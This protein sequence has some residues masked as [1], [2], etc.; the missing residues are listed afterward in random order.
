MELNL[1]ENLKKYRQEKGNTQD[2]L[3]EFLNMSKQSVSKWERDEGFP[4]I[5][6]LP[7][8][9]AYYDVTVDDLLGCGEIE[10]QRRLTEFEEQ[11]QQLVNQNRMTD[12]LILCRT[13]QKEYPNEKRVLDYLMSALG[14]EDRG[15]NATEIIE[16]AERLLASGDPEYRY[17]ALQNLTMTYWWQ[18]DYEQAKKYAAMAESPGDLML[19]ALRG[20]ERL[21]HCRRYFWHLCDR[22]TG[23]MGYLFDDDPALTAAEKYDC[24]RLN[25]DLYHRIFRDG[26][27]GFFE[28]RLAY[29]C[30]DLAKYSMM[31]GETSRALGEL[32]DGLE[33]C[34]KYDEFVSI[35]HSSP[36]VR[37]Q[38]YED[39][40]AGR[41]GCG[42]TSVLMLETMSEPCFDPIREDERFKAV[43]NRL[44]NMKK[45]YPEQEFYE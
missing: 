12:Y 19:F 30:C 7:K 8:I 43:V 15:K 16:I 29:L 6:L 41:A 24:V 20:E 36:L 34:R 40:M 5:T 3:A 11:L 27:F 37:G 9:A 26:D 13:M 1:A 44:N 22:M 42:G 31:L 28:N 38:H 21:D 18:N 39:S 25:C 35:D 2:E 4:D 33:H 14:F 32:E 10:K 45:V 17:S 23:Y